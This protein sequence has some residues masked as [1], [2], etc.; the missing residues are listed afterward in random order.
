[1]RE[2]DEPGINAAIQSLVESGL[3]GRSGYSVVGDPAER[4]R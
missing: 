1:M 3:A 2:A 4:R